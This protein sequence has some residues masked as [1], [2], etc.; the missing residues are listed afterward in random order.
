MQIMQI[1]FVFSLFTFLIKYGLCE[2]YISVFFF[3]FF[4]SIYSTIFLHYCSVI[5]FSG[6]VL[7]IRMLVIRM[8]VIDGKYVSMR[9]LCG[10]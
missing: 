1:N 9:K 6:L 10:V 5:A 2:I 4:L 8:N 3:H 7:D